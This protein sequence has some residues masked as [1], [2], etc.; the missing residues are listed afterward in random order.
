MAKKKMTFSGAMSKAPKKVWDDARNTDVGGKRTLPEI[1]DGT[2]PCRMK[3]MKCD[4]DKYDKP[5]VAITLVVIEGEYE[6][7]VLDKFHSLKVW[8]QDLPRLV[9]TL[10]GAGYEFPEDEEAGP[11]LEGIA[12]DVAENEPEVMVAVANGTYTA[13]RDTEDYKKGDEVPMLNVY[14]NRPCSIEEGASVPAS[15]KKAP[16]KKAP[17][18]KAPTKK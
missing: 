15:V 1:E 10:K 12:A 2:Y 14:I 6:G 11:L 4:T 8:D 13:T 7:V 18:K 17:A 9:K 5:Y 3:K 16:A